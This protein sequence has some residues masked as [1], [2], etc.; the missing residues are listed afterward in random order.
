MSY[1]ILKQG[2]LTKK[3]IFFL[4]GG[5][6]AVTIFFTVLFSLKEQDKLNQIKE[7]Q[8]GASVQSLQANISKADKLGVFEAKDKNLHKDMVSNAFKNRKQILNDVSAKTLD[9]EDFAKDYVKYQ[10]RHALTDR[11]YKE[12]DNSPDKDKFVTRTVSFEDFDGAPKEDEI[13]QNKKSKT[14]S[15]Y[16]EQALKASSKV[17]LELKHHGLGNSL[18]DK[19]DNQNGDNATPSFT[20]PKLNSLDG[21][22]D[23]N[24]QDKP[25]EN[26]LESYD[27]LKR[28]NYVLK[29]E[30]KNPKTP[31]ALM[32]GSVIHATLL[33]GINSELPGL[34]TAQISRDVHDSIRAKYLLIPRGSKLVGQYASGAA[35]GTERLFIGFNRIIF[36][37]GQS[38]N[39]GSMPGQSTNGYAGFD[40]QVDNHY[41]KIIANSLLLSSISTTADHYED[42][43]NLAG[44]HQR[45][46]AGFKAQGSSNVSQ[47]LAKIIE[48]NIN[49]SPTLSVEPGYAFTV[50]ITQDI[51]F[52]SPYGAKANVHFKK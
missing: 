24:S 34:I 29:S 23:S 11:S 26:T 48:R 5:F 13:T 32:Q 3:P 21:P 22:S 19:I 42:T 44:G 46:I 31:F 45:T 2:P 35:F 30:V 27:K 7:K 8:N 47:A 12:D 14:N 51:F 36:P 28:N 9:D 1:T 4:I 37:N 40:A 50:A 10:E 39:L 15:E 16:Y 33:N 25:N 18:L 43:Y 17:N 20:Q 38:I 41:F 6:I 49:L 52:K